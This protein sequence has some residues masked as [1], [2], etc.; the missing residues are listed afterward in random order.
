MSFIQKNKQKLI[1]LTLWLIIVGGFWIYAQQNNLSPT[2]MVQELS[3]FLQ[4]N[5]LG[6]LIFLAIFLIRPLLFFPNSMLMLLA[7]FLYG[8]LLGLV[9]GLTGETIS[10][11]IAYGIGLHFGTGLSQ[12]EKSRSR[13]GQYADALKRNGFESVLVMRLLLFNVDFVSYSAGI[14]QVNWL[15]FL[16]ATALGSLAGTTA[17]ILAGAS[18]EGEFTGELPD[19]DPLLFSVAAILFVGSLVIAWYVR[20]RQRQAESVSG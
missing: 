20:R 19:L 13:L 9:L 16:G 6:P 4:E 5:P 2:E 15:S 8:P 18:I 10:A 11:M 12:V 17:Y 7:G 14:L 3:Y 1:P